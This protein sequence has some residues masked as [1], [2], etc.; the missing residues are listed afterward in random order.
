MTLLA[1]SR[2]EQPHWTSPNLQPLATM[3]V[4]LTP[5]NNKEGI[6]FQLNTRPSSPLFD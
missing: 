4:I 6:I 3:E 1:L 5:S 2:N